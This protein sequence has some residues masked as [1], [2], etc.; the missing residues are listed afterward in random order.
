[1]KGVHGFLVLTGYYRKFIRDHGKVAE[2]R[3]ELTNK[4]NFVWGAEA[5]TTLKQMN[6]IMTSPQVMVLPNFSQPFE[7]DFDAASRGIGAVLMQYREPIAFFSKA[8][9]D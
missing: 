5:I 6:K 7:V 8:L 4:D 2:P 3:I 9:S 1:M